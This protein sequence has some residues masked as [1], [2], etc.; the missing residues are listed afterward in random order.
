MNNNNNNEMPVLQCHICGQSM[1]RAPPS[2]LKRHYKTKRCVT[3]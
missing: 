2:F 1:K 3:A